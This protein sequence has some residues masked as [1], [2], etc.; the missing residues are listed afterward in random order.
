MANAFHSS[1]IGIPEVDLYSKT[2]KLFFCSMAA[3]QPLL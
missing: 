2:N 1:G 3:L